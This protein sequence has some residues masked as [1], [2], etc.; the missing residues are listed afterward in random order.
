MTKLYVSVKQI[1]NGQMPTL[2]LKSKITLKYVA[3]VHSNCHQSDLHFCL[4]AGGVTI[5]ALKSQM[6]QPV[7]Q[8]TEPVKPQVNN[9]VFRTLTFHLALR[10]LKF[11]VI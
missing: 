6:S 9:F 10:I 3:L 8:A 4:F 11:I 2:I 5:T 7:A 1:Q